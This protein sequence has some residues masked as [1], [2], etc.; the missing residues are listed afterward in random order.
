MR[1]AL[2]TGKSS[3]SYFEPQLQDF[4]GLL[5]AA[6]LASRL[7][8]LR[9]PKEL[10]PVGLV[11][12]VTTG[13]VF[14][15]VTAEYSLL[16]MRR[17]GLKKCIIVTNSNKPEILRYFANGSEF[18]M[19]IAY[20]N[21]SAPLGLALA[22]DTAFA[23]IENAYVCL[24]LPDTL[25]FPANALAVV[26]E[27]LVRDNADLVLGVFPTDTPQQL[28]PVRMTEDGRVL[29][30]FEKPV[31]TDLNN[32]WGVAAWAPRFTSFVHRSA[33]ELVNRSIGCL[34]GEAV[35]A[36]FRVRAVY[37]EEGDYVDLGTEAQLA[38]TFG[39]RVWE[40]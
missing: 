12:D 29:E 7:P 16:A 30:V 25:F 22:V 6:G 8:S 2:L 32:T 13:K 19:S 4:V 35:Q 5:P 39:G 37:F 10:I 27:S 24:S 17:A 1:A 11:K 18:G 33:T 20:V 28:G 21:Q 23:W 26:R 38:A 3:E 9:S 14:P 15:I 34:F 40:L 31:V 36:G